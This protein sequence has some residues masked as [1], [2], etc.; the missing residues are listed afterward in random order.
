MP[1]V[2][3]HGAARPASAPGAKVAPPRGADHNSRMAFRTSHSARPPRRVVGESREELSW[4]A[5]IAFICGLS[6]LGWCAAAGAAIV[7]LG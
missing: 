3:G 6:L 2:L 7:V 5:A 1:S 4:R